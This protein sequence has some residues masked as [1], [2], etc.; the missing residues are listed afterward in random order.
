MKNLRSEDEPS[1][2]PTAVLE[3]LKTTHLSKIK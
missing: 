2:N 1:F 3:S